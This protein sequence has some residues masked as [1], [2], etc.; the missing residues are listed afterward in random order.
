M[1]CNAGGIDLDP[2]VND[3]LKQTDGNLKKRFRAIKTKVGR[4]SLK[5]DVERITAMSKHLGPDFPLMVDANMKWSADEAI[6]QARAL[7]DC[8]LVWLDEPIIPDDVGGHVRVMRDGGIP[9]ETGEN[10]RTHWEF[11]QMISAGG[12]SYPRT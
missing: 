4:A 12:V 5:E 7:R 1:P 10:M 6:R 2:S 11:Q 3:L 8:D 9:I